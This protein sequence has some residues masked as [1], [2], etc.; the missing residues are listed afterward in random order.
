MTPEG[1]RKAKARIKSHEGIKL[2]MY[3]DETG[4]RTIGWGHC[5]DIM[6]ITQHAADTILDDDIDWFLDNIPRHWPAFLDLDMP[7]QAAILDIVYNIGLHSFMRFEKMIHAIE[8][9]NWEE[10]SRQLLDSN[11]AKQNINRTQENADV[12]LTGKLQ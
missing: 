1:R 7:R 9:Q 6:P 3:L 10:A 11:L 12:L 5:I 4:H 8:S 2:Q